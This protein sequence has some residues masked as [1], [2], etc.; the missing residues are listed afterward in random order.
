MLKLSPKWQ[1]RLP[2]PSLCWMSRND[3]VTVRNKLLGLYFAS[4]DY[5]D[6]PVPGD[7]SGQ[8]IHVY[9]ASTSPRLEWGT[10]TAWLKCPKDKNPYWDYC[11][12]LDRSRI[13]SAPFNHSSL[14]SAADVVSAFNNYFPFKPTNNFIVYDELKEM[15]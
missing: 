1:N 11:V 10:M 4:D 7:T 12:D 15:N 14:S 5:I 3:I 13:F 9:P 6:M 2:R 8:Y